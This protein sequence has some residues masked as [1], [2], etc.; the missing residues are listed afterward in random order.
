M[1]MHRKV[2][3]AILGAMLALVLVA[4]GS[5]VARELQP[6]PEDAI[7][8]I[9]E[10]I[11]SAPSAQPAKPRKVLVF[12]LCEG[13]FHGSIPFGNRCFEI[14][15]EKTKAFETVVSE[16][17]AMFDSEHL[18][19]FDAVL[20]NNTTRLSFTEPKHRE[21]LMAFIKSGKGV[22]GIHGATDNFYDWPEA[23][24]MMGGLFDGHPWGGGGTW[25][26]KIDEPM[27]P[28]N[29]P[30]GGRG[31]LIKDEIYQ[32]KGPYS[33]DTHRV[34]LSLDM[35]NPRNVKG[36]RPDNDNAIS[37]LRKVGEGRVFY[38]SLG[39]NNEIFWNPAVVRHYLDGIQYA[40]GDLK[41]CDVPSAKLTGS[42]APK[43]ALTT[44]PGAVDDPHK[45]VEPLKTK[46]L[47]AFRDPLGEWQVVGDT[48]KDAAD[49]KLLATKPGEGVAING[50]KGRTSHLVTK[51]EFGDVE[52][53]IEFMVPKGSNSGVYFAGRYEIQVLDSWGVEKP[54]SSEC[55]GIY[56]RWGAQGGF[57]GRPPTV[58]AAKEP[59]QWQTFD[60]VFRAPRFDDAGNKVRN[61]MFLKVNH[62]GQVV[63]EKQEVT[64]PTRAAMFND[65]KP[66]GPIMFQGDHG[67]VAYR[68]IQIKP[69]RPDP[70]AFIAT[71]EFGYSRRDL[72][73][74][75]DEIRLA[76]PEELS[77]I[78]DKLVHALEC[79]ETTF[80]GKQFVC[81]MLRR[82]GTAKCV[83]ALAKRL[84]DKDLAHMARFALQR[85]PSPTADEALAAA[86]DQVECPDLKIGIIGSLG[87]RQ[88]C[89]ACAQLGKYVADKNMA[90][91]KAA[92]Q[93]LGRLGCEEAAE[94]LMKTKLACCIASGPSCD[95][96]TCPKAAQSSG[97]QAGAATCP[98][99]QQAECPQGQQVACAACPKAPCG[100]PC[101]AGGSCPKA[102][103]NMR[104]VK[105][106][107]ILM[108]ADKMLESDKAGKAAAIYRKM[109]CPSQATITR[110]AAYRGL[111]RAEKDKAPLLVLRLL[112][113]ENPDV[114]QA[115]GKFVADLCPCPLATELLASQLKPLE[116]DAQVA[117]AAALGSRGDK[118]A[119]GGVAAAAASENPAVRA[120]ASKALG[121]L[122]GATD[123]EQLV[124]VAANASDENKA[125][126]AAATMALTR[127]TGKGVSDALVRT[128]NT[129]EDKAVQAKAIEAI[130]ARLDRSALPA[131]LA[132]ASKGEP[133]SDDAKDA[134]E[135]REQQSQ[136]R[137][138]AVKALGTLAGEIE[139]PQML[140]ILLTNVST[141]ERSGIEKA[142]ASVAARIK[143]AGGC[144]A[145]Q[146]VATIPRADD[147]AKV[148]LLALLARIGGGKAL[149]AVRC[150]AQGP[151]A[152]V[153]KA[154]VRAMGE[155]PDVAPMA[156]LLAVAQR[157]A[158]VVLRVLAV[159]GYVRLIGLKSE[160]SAEETLA[161]YEKA[162]AATERPDEKRLVLGGVSNV[163]L[164]GALEL[165]E[166]LLAVEELQAEA[167]QAY[168]RVAN[169]IAQSDPQ[170]AKAAYKKIL[171]VSQDEGVVKRVKE[172][173]E[174]IEA[175]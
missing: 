15:G 128:V 35:S 145:T 64:G 47:Q 92:I 46:D 82:M 135:Y 1:R 138:A 63:H 108:C 90:I 170:T 33:R 83:P 111:V 19:T 61:A 123:V 95:K 21:A 22:I 12:Y 18:E 37:W 48:L 101:C 105:A 85:N 86:L 28:L 174:K 119:A 52:A 163:S 115:A 161:L 160:R 70:Y 112:R 8:Q 166:P 142:L 54:T 143:A 100:K 91:A 45:A 96:A 36:A 153:K 125:S 121:V 156:D 16:D 29:Q 58:N 122:G 132:A 126:A 32:M 59:G 40:L 167:V 34:L 175:Q 118:A 99:A 134:K 73:L 107:A 151:N 53:H 55:G 60:V 84:G 140:A 41:V 65:E 3:T 68:N 172:N 23:A 25:A 4:G 114:R 94:I 169:S 24:E 9:T 147:G 113:D 5:A 162:M 89:S 171:D 116:A 93:A 148:N 110:I 77:A 71:Y 173:L 69:L 42:H 159:Q 79:P 56:Q 124:A 157:G 98:Q 131:L 103:C 155:W 139:L 20:F 67:P 133:L 38:C 62:N 66:S 144:A 87:D 7:K 43:P 129:A 44:A 31:F 6:V 154:A 26:V 165:I 158:D 149:D 27:H 17:M 39:H 2:W 164:A 51:E 72:S 127:L 78:E 30:F 109:S 11:P 57:E 168:E 88:R 136:V 81:R 97:Q 150:E 13:F 50:A 117:L 80:A 10:A 106:D 152:D 146:V 137:R 120:A 74:I 141:S 14:M 102:L 130:E 75:E 49:E 104:R 76:T